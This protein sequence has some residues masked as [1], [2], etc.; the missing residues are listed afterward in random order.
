VWS[1]YVF[2]KALTGMGYWEGLGSLK[3]EQVFCEDLD[4]SSILVRD[5]YS[6]KGA[7]AGAFVVLQIRE[8]AFPLKVSKSFAK[9][10][11]IYLD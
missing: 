2:L 3:E 5:T 4:A 1:Y 10:Y 11:L 8:K 7:L 9:T 6:N